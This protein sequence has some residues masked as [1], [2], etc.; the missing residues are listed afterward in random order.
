LFPV[1]IKETDN[2]YVIVADTPGM[3]KD[4]LKIRITPDNMLIIEGQRKDE[5]E[6]RADDGRV[7]RVERTFGRFE[8]RFILPPNVDPQ[9]IKAKTENGVLRL[10]VPKKHEET[11]EYHE[12]PID[13]ADAGG[14]GTSGSADLGSVGRS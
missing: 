6:E 2:E 12:I 4:D 1:D 14:A 10:I 9:H 8:R 13:G 3:S 5:H 11:P 7:Y